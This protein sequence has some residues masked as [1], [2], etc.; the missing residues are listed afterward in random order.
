MALGRA[1]CTAASAMARRWASYGRLLDSPDLLSSHRQ[2]GAPGAPAAA[3]VPG[4]VGEGQAA[5][6]REPEQRAQ[7]HDGVVTPVTGQRLQG[8]CRR[9]RR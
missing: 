4:G 9:H 6:F 3:E 8:R 7:R 5:A 2:H 1:A